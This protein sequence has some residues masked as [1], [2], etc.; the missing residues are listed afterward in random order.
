MKPLYYSK[1]LKV[2]MNT[3]ER[4]LKTHDNSRILNGKLNKE[5]RGKFNKV[6]DDYNYSSVSPIF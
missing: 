2:L 3:H 5:L 4:N 1:V 6:L